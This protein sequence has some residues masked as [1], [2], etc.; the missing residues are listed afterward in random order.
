M[1]SLILYSVPLVIYALVAKWKNKAGWHDIAQ[2]LGL[3]VSQKPYYWWTLGFALVGVAFSWVV[4]S[5]I[6]ES[7]KNEQ[8]MAMSRF[9]GER[10]TATNI[11]ALFVFGT[12]HRLRHR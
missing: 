12:N 6:P 4:W 11:L 5:T 7:I 1:T 2:R 9:A 8:L 3:A 10:L